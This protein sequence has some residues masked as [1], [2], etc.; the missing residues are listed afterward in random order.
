MEIEQ[1]EFDEIRNES[2][3]LGGLLLEINGEIPIKGATIV[4][5]RFEFIVESVDKR[6]IKRVKV[7]R[8]TD[9]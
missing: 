2:D 8:K 3:T 7:I 5:N 6:R 9:E 1:S 4:F